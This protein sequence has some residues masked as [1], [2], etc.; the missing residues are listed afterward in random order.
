MSIVFE[1][2]GSSPWIARDAAQRL[3]RKLIFPADI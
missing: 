3:S 2:G 1:N